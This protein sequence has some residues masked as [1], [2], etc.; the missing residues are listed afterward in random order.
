MPMTAKAD[1]EFSPRSVELQFIK[2]TWPSTMPALI[3]PNL[4]RGK[5]WY[6]E[7]GPPTSET[8]LWSAAFTYG[9]SITCWSS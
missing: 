7:A 2:A 6:N 4:H 3:A 1:A 5:V 9:S 8:L